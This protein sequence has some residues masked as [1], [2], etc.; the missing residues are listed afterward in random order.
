M[1]AHAMQ[2]PAS[3]EQIPVQT[4]PTA[5][6]VTPQPW[7]KPTLTRLALKDALAGAV[8]FDMTDSPS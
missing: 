1:E 6:V 3:S 5:V 2:Q 8:T 7:M 4:A